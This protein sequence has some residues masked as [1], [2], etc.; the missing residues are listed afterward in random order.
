[1]KKDFGD[2][3]HNPRPVEPSK[4]RAQATGIGQS[5]AMSET[6]GRRRAQHVADCMPPGQRAAVPMAEGYPAPTAA[7]P[8]MTSCGDY[9]PARRG[10][11]N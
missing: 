11:A 8:V 5:Q 2:L 1:M 3:T 7:D 4:F 10:R 6:T 9:P